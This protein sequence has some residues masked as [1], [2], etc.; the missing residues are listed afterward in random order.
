MDTPASP[1]A[2]QPPQR[3]ALEAQAHPQTPH[4]TPERVDEAR[5]RFR[6]FLKE[7]GQR[8]TPER[9]AILDAIY[10]TPDH[11]DADTLFVRLKQSGE[12]L[13]RATVYNTLELLVACQLV[14][15]HQFGQNQAR[16][17]RAFSYWQH[18]HLICQQCNQIYEFCDPRL[19]QIQQMIGEIYGFEVTQHSLN[20]Y[21]VCTKDECR[22]AG[23]IE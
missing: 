4:F 9:F 11:V 15:R 19:H 6:A 1:N 8:Q 2:P 22:A 17:E 7:R 3:A 5:E 20:L 10:A 21:G 13:S 16:Y 23:R 14:V 12:R 18:D